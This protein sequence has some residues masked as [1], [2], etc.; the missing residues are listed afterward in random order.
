[1]IQADYDQLIEKLQ[2][3]SQ[4]SEP[5][6]L[7]LK[8]KIVAL[9]ESGDLP[10]GQGL[11]AERTLAEALNLS[12]TT[13]RRSYLELRESGM[14]GAHGQGGTLV[15]AVPRISP[16]LGKLKGFTEEMGE[17]GMVANT[18]VLSADLTSDRT[19]ASVFARPSTATFLRLVR[20]RLAD[21][22]PM[23]REIAWYDLTAAPELTKWDRVGSAYAYLEAQCNIKLAWAE[24]SIE[25]II[26]SDEESKAFGFAEN[27]PCL[28]LKRKSFTDNNQLIEY[29]EGT[30]RGDAYA[31]RLKLTV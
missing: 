20:L 23:T 17:L 7:Q 3:N 30:F 29:V 25:A 9:I 14:L 11:P 13:V 16:K 2:L 1:M 24:Q 15:N 18:L 12:R 26:S 4:T 10:S 28:L 19:I 8:R 21:N 27:G 5:Y 6:Y 22:V 31:Y